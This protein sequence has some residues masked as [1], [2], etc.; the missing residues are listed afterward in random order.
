M[1]VGPPPRSPF[2]LI[3][4][5]LWSSSPDSEWLILVSC[6]LL[7]CTT[8]KQVDKVIP[9]FMKRWPSPDE[10]LSSDRDDV[11]EVIRSLG[12]VNRRVRVLFAMTSNYRHRTWTH[13]SELP[14]IGSYGSRAWEIFCR[15]IIGDSIPEDHALVNYWK[16]IKN[17]R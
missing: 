5:D 1:D 11:A 6:V 12:F 17:H 9:E 14:G 2:G 3:Q 13:V 16:W 10:F 8:R 15:Q 7:N 4:E